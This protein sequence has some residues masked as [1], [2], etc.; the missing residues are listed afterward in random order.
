IHPSVFIIFNVFVIEP[1]AMPVCLLPLS[2]IP[3][4]SSCKPEGG[5]LGNIQE[6]L[7]RGSSLPKGVSS[8]RSEPGAQCPAPIKLPDFLQGHGSFCGKSDFYHLF[9]LKI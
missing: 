1:C 5:S 4:E 9:L 6:L 7:G 2:H 3:D 8:T